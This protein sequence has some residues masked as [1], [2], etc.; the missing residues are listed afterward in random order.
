MSTPLYIE[1]PAITKFNC[2]SVLYDA[3]GDPSISYIALT[4]DKENIYFLKNTSGS[5]L[6]YN[7]V[8]EELS[9][10]EIA[11]IDPVYSILKYKNEIYGFAGYDVKQFVGD[12]V[13]YVRNNNELVQES[14][15]RSAQA[16]HLASK[17]EISDFFIDDNMNYYVIHNGNKI[18]KFTKDRVPVYS[19][20]I[21]PDVN[22][23]FNTL[24][25][26]P[27]DEIQILKFDYVREYT[28]SGT[29]TYPIIL[30]VFKWENLKVIFK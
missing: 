30:V 5:V 21:T 25:V 19:F 1:V 17:T 10:F 4:Y 26:M 6:K 9:S 24:G 27:N 29:N 20:N 22:T 14:Y 13:L 23:V 18:S 11:I 2:N 12:T 16:V 15:D 3:I 7:I 8:S 28:L